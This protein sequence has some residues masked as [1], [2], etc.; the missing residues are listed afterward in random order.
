MKRVTWR[1]GAL[2]ARWAIRVHRPALAYGAVELGIG[3]CAA[4]VTLVLPMLTVAY[5]NGVNAVGLQVSDF[6]I[7]VARPL[8][9]PVTSVKM[10]RSS[11]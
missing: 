8:T 4:A 3:L 1:G 5:F 9:F 6:G 2:G 10:I 7:V 11:L